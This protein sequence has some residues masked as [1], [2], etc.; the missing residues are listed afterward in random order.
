MIKNTYGT[1]SFI[2][3]NT[4]ENMELSKNKPTNNYRLWN[5][6]EKY[7]THSKVLSLSQEVLSNGL[8]TVYD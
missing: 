5:K 8:E 1:G 7:T 3:M 2:I 4:G 6:T